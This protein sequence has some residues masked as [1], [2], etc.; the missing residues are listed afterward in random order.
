MLLALGLPHAIAH[1]SLRLTVSENNTDEEIDYILEHVPAI[2]ER[3]RNM[4]PVWDKA[5][6]RMIMEDDNLK[7]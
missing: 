7:K 2:I 4:S 6:Q 3:L 5:N 1:G